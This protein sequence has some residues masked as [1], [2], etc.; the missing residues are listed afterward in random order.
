MNSISILGYYGSWNIGDA[1]QTIAMESL[2]ARLHHEDTPCV[3]VMRNELPGVRKGNLLVNGWLRNE[4]ETPDLHAG[5]EARFRFCGIHTVDFPAMLDWLRFQ[6]GGVPIG[7]RDP[8]TVISLGRQGIPTRLV[9]CATLTL[10]NTRPKGEQRSGIYA[11]DVA[12]KTG[13]TELTHSIP[14]DQSWE[15]QR[16]R[17]QEL[18][19]LYMRAEFVRTSRLHV[20]LPCLAFGTPVQ[21]EHGEGYQPERMSLL[22]VLGCNIGDVLENVD[23]SDMVDA[24]L[25]HLTACRDSLLNKKTM[26]LHRSFNNKNFLKKEPP[27][28]LEAISGNSHVESQHEECFQE[29]PSLSALTL[30][31]QHHAWSGIMY[32]YSDGTFQGGN[33]LPHGTWRPAQEGNVLILQ[34]H[35]WPVN[36]LK[37][38]PWGF[39]DKELRLEFFDNQEAEKWPKIQLFA[40][41]FYP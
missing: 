26:I 25:L 29:N 11:V 5:C 22:D 24:F 19:N 13:E 34:W 18:L 7:C 3:H 36:S 9:G 40:A 8:W 21:W 17:A 28:S 12:A 39:E 20:I 32:L 41:R 15:S 38:Q 1:I 6:D 33:A 30:R 23:C 10:K 35:H 2:L 14:R 37:L 16:A 4:W 31:A 27:H